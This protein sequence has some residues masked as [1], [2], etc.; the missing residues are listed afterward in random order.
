MTNVPKVEFGALIQDPSTGRYLFLRRVKASEVLSEEWDIPGGERML[1]DKGL[2]GLGWDVKAQ[3]G[4]QLNGGRFLDK[5]YGPDGE[6]ERLIFLA[7]ASGKMS[8]NT[9]FDWPLWVGWPYAR[10]SLTM[11][12]EL[13]S[14][15]SQ[16]KQLNKIEE[17]AIHLASE[18][19]RRQ[20]RG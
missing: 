6:S 13:I 7:H 16:P 20:V 2:E 9:T 3:T 17:Y 18:R 4:L 14:A 1:H 12:P 5:L 10:E 19:I 8:L 15:I 11:K